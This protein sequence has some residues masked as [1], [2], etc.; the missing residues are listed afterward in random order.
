MMEC[1]KCGEIATMAYDNTTVEDPGW[2]VESNIPVCAVCMEGADTE[3][4]A[5]LTPTRPCPTC[6]KPIPE[7]LE[8][9]SA[10]CSIAHYR[11]P[12]G[13]PE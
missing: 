3:M 9:C 1:L 7:P 10:D 11:T 13:D 2:P 5:N 8:F 12:T 6:G 4:A